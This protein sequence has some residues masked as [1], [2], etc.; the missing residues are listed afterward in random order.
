TS[1][2]Q[3]IL[4]KVRP[5]WQGRA[6]QGVNTDKIISYIAVTLNP[7]GT[8]AGSPRLMKQDGVDD[9]NRAQAGRH[10]EEA[11]RAIRL[12][13]PFDLPADQYELWKNLPPLA[14]RKS[15]NQ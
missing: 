4:R 12:A 11:I 1:F 13:A 8:L 6:P 10:A 9:T 15:A 2:A 3:S 14:F 5:E 7:D